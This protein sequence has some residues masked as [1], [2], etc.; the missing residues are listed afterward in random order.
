[1]A[2]L[3][4]PPVNGLCGVAGRGGAARA[5]RQ[6]APHTEPGSAASRR[7][8]DGRRHSAEHWES[9]L[10]PY[11]YPGFGFVTYHQQGGTSYPVSYVDQATGFLPVA[12]T[13]AVINNVECG[14]VSEVPVSS[15]AVTGPQDFKTKFK[16][17]KVETTEPLKRGRWTCI[18][19]VDKPAAKEKEVAGPA[20]AG[21]G[22]GEAG[23]T[24]SQHGTS[25]PASTLPREV[26]AEEGGEAGEEGG[27]ATVEQTAPTPHQAT[28]APSSGAGSEERELEAAAG[29][30]AGRGSAPPESVRPG[31]LN[32]TLAQ[33]VL[34]GGAGAGVGA[35]QSPGPGL[36]YSQQVL[37]GQV[38]RLPDGQLA[39]VALAPLPA[40]NQQPAA[41]AVQPQPSQQQIMLKIIPGSSVAQQPVVVRDAAGQHFIV[42]GQSGQQQA[43]PASQ[44]APVQPSS[45]A[46]QQQATTRNVQ[47]AV[48]STVGQQPQ[49]A[50]LASQ[51]A[52]QASPPL[53][54]GHSQAGPALISG[55]QHIVTQLPGQQSQVQLSVGPDVATQ[56]IYMQAPHMG[57]QPS[58]A[59]HLVPSQSQAQHLSS[60]PS[61]PHPHLVSQASQAPHLASQ[62]SQA[63]HLASQPAPVPLL[64]SQA[65]PGPVKK[66][67]GQ[68]GVAGGSAAVKPGPVLPPAS[69]SMQV[70]AA[71]TAPLPAQP[72][73]PQSGPPASRPQPTPAPSAAV[74]AVTVITAA[75]P[76]PRTAPAPVQNGTVTGKPNIAV[77]VVNSGVSSG[78]TTTTAQL[79]T[80]LDG[81][82]L[83]ERLEDLVSTQLGEDGARDG[84]LEHER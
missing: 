5:G 45:G 54:P 22:T 82:G 76:A 8:S 29:K 51:A 40:S 10:P 33:P 16:V 78:V 18:D 48:S 2:A 36:D 81:E 60:Q 83:V 57:V 17:V 77:S 62:A 21:T 46:P 64:A 74:A 9:G 12:G 14:G 55:Q 49:P 35:V 41:P 32:I 39:Q 59:P 25:R 68:S 47:P 19:F 30:V 34:P 53:L 69:Q 56:N 15:Q 4:N 37:P 65:G 3:S 71:S 11:S 31:P 50:L 84:D 73:L 6:S 28:P 20:A 7:G 79:D 42:P 80:R 70:A 66:V 52:V 61:Q 24:N 38:V 44:P 58:Q 26:G 67:S 43:G 75:G 23:R 27:V 63:P 1:M 72:L 13:M